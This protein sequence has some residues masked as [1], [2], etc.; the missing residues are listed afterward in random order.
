MKNDRAKITFQLLK[1]H[2]KK[3]T[4]PGRTNNSVELPNLLDTLVRDTS[5]SA[6]VSY[7]S[8]NQ[9]CRFTEK[10]V[11]RDAFPMLLWICRD[12]TRRTTRPI[13]RC[14]AY[15]QRCI[16]FQAYYQKQFNPYLVPGTWYEIV[17]PR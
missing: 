9:S 13:G 14:V 15:I 12:V 5:T 3:I 4:Y 1:N 8:Y 10:K 6:G 7:Q 11:D 2:A 17:P 16:P